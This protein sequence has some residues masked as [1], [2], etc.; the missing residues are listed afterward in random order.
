MLSLAFSYNYAE[1]HYAECPNAKRR[2]GEFHYA[3]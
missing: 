3:K 1:F 2:Y